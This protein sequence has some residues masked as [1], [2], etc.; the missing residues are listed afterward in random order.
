MGN[1][2]VTGG[3]NIISGKTY[4]IFQNVVS[5]NP[6]IS[7]LAPLA[8]AADL[9]LSGQERAEN[10]PF[11]PCFRRILKFLM[12]FDIFQKRIC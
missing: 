10:D 11:S 7:L 2:C 4:V 8:L 5:Q 6:K 9:N 3:G 1:V 12:F